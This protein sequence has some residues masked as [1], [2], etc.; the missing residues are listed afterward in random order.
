[1]Q[2]FSISLAT[3]SAIICPGPD[4]IRLGITFCPIVSAGCCF[5]GG[6]AILSGPFLF[7][8][9]IFRCSAIICLARSNFGISPVSCIASSRLVG[10]SLTSG[11]SF[12]AVRRVFSFEDRF[13]FLSS[14]SLTF[15]ALLTATTSFNA[16]HSFLLDFCSIFIKLNALHK[17]NTPRGMFRSH[18]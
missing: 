1:M 11:A 14:L 6:L 7:I 5:L 12:A 3:I 10:G 9:V 2:R 18:P 15:L 4:N 17:H 8:A 16:N 13:C